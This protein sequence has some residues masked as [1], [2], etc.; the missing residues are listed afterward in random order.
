MSESSNCGFLMK[1][2]TDYI[3]KKTNRHLREHDITLTQVQ[4]LGFL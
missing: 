3:S 2:I 1:Q 4:V